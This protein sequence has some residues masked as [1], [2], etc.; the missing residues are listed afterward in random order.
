MKT[1][2]AA[3]FLVL[4]SAG[5]GIGAEPVTTAGPYDQ[6]ILSER[7][8]AVN[9]ILRENELAG[10]KAKTYCENDWNTWVIVIKHGK[11]TGTFTTKSGPGEYPVTGTIG[12]GQKGIHFDR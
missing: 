9:D 5:F 10:K 2:V 7:L 3:L 4:V 6:T 11:I 12:A 8:D 1:L